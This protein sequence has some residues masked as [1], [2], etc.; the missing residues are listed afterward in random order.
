MVHHTNAWGRDGQSWKCRISHRRS[1]LIVLFT[2][3]AVAEQLMHLTEQRQDPYVAGR[4]SAKR[5]SMGTCKSKIRREVGPGARCP[6]HARRGG[7]RSLP[8]GSRQRPPQDLE[9]APLPSRM[10]CQHDQRHASAIERISSDDSDSQSYY[11]WT[12]SPPCEFW[13]ADKHARRM[14]MQEKGLDLVEEI[15]EHRSQS[16]FFRICILCLL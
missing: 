11:K 6:I 15:E 16:R 10:P 5:E 9:I 14:S 12:K 8:E 7:R 1:E 2:S 13:E 3:E 4:A